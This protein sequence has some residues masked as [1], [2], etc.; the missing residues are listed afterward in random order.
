[1]LPGGGETKAVSATTSTREA[2]I[3]CG[4]GA[5]QVDSTGVGGF[6]S[7]AGAGYR[8][9]KRQSGAPTPY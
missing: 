3:P 1:V 8:R 5:A 9:T 6:G 4:G 2:K 7:M